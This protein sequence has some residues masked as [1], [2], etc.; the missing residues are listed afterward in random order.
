MVVPTH[1]SW[2]FESTHPPGG[3]RRAEAH[4][5]EEEDAHDDR[6][7]VL[8]RRGAQ[9]SGGRQ[10]E[11]GEREHQKHRVRHHHLG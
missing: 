3:D 2:L 11:H 4:H 10:R 7:D 6:G 5:K 9:R 1:Y 8:A